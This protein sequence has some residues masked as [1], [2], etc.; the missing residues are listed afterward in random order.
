MLLPLGF[1]ISLPH[2]EWKSK[3]NY[4]WNV[5]F[6]SFC[7][8][9]LNHGAQSQFID[10]SKRSY[11][12]CGIIILPLRLIKWIIIFVYDV[13]LLVYI[14]EFIQVGHTSMTSVYF[15]LI[16]A[17]FLDYTSLSTSTVGVRLPARIT[18]HKWSTRTYA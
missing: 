1:H 7:L 10:L 3:F 11:P 12:V 4:Q 13:F 18:S 6:N 5:T 16:S 17:A 9:P 15:S 14:L 8:V 2:Y